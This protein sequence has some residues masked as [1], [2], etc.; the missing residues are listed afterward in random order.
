LVDDADWVAARCCH[1]TLKLRWLP[2]D[3]LSPVPP[4]AAK[5]VGAT[6]TSMDWCAVFKSTTSQSLLD[7]F[8]GR[9]ETFG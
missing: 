3:E 1:R 8:V 2:D 4:Q 9:R 7:L 6:A 5:H